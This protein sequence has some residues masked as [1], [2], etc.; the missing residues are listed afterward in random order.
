MTMSKCLFYLLNINGS[1]PIFNLMLPP[2]QCFSELGKQSIHCLFQNELLLL[3]R[4]MMRILRHLIQHNS[5]LRHMLAHDDSIYFA[6]LR[7]K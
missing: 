5:G 4:P 3:A 2:S 7:C 6:I 1:L